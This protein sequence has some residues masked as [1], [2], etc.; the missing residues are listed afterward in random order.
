MQPGALYL[1]PTLLSPGALAPISFEVRETIPEMDVYLVENLRTARRYISSLK[2]GV[3]IEDLQF[4]LLDKD[5]PDALL[6]SYISLIREGKNAAV[7]SE[8][9]CPGIADPGARM[10]NLAHRNGIKVLPLSGPSSIFLSLMGSGLD[11]QHFTF[12]GYLPIERR[13][14]Q[15]AL[16]RLDKSAGTHIFIETPYRNKQMFEAI[17]DTCN[18]ATR[19]CIAYDLTGPK[20]LIKTSSVADWQGQEPDFHKIPCVF[21]LGK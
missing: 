12:H 11:G 2:L 3:Q 6:Q 16:A 14:R 18:P 4:E 17:L 5:T 20:Q 19:L 10:V 15:R 8:S 21:L 1:I 13:D 7:I 9:G